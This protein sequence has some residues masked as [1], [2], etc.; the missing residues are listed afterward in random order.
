[1]FCSI[2]QNLTVINIFLDNHLNIPYYSE[3]EFLLLLK[4]TEKLYQ[5]FD[6]LSTNSLSGVSLALDRWPVAT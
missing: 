5:F 4:I 2:V 6:K 1:M 3:S